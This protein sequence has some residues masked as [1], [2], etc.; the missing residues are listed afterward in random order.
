[1]MS[2][3]EAMSSMR[4]SDKEGGDKRNNRV[5]NGA[6]ERREW[7]TEQAKERQDEEKSEGEESEEG[8]GGEESEESEGDEEFEQF[9][10]SIRGEVIT[11]KDDP[12]VYDEA[13]QIWNGDWTIKNCPKYIVH[14]RGVSDVQKA[15]K[16]ARKKDLTVTVRCGGHSL[17]GLSTNVGGMVIDLGKYMRSVRVD[18]KNMEVWF[19]GGCRVQDIDSETTVFNLCTMLGAV[20]N[21][22]AGGLVTGGGLGYF[23]RKEGLSVDNV[24]GV[25][26]VDARGNFVRADANENSDLYWGVRGAQSN[27]GIVTGFKMRL[28]PCPETILGGMVL[29]ELKHAKELLTKYASFTTDPKLPRECT[30]HMYSLSLPDDTNRY[31]SLQVCY[32]GPSEEGYKV[33]NP[34][35]HCVPNVVNQVQERTYHEYQT[36]SDEVYRVKGIPSYW[37]SRNVKRGLVLPVDK[38]IECIRISPAEGIFV[39]EHYGGKIAEFPEDHAAYPHRD[40]DLVFTFTGFGF[41]DSEARDRVKVWIDKCTETLSDLYTGGSYTNYE[42][43]SALE[44]FAKNLPRLRKLKR[45]YDPDNFFRC[46]TNVE[47]AEE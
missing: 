24:T 3:T 43:G 47:P 2:F 41:Q 15:V 10:K 11:D 29:Y 44:S 19:E 22:G 38:I 40:N 16:F 25:E 45:R 28:F 46:N 27:F 37:R 34:L 20:G 39:I 31:V 6:E 4:L 32:L 42:C 14:C 5:E 30:V 9:W 26:V 33:L 12:A 13:K 21:A 18:Q 8:E 36:F 35:L 23:A 7:E 1:L 17:K